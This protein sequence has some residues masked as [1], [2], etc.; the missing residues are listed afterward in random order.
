VSVHLSVCLSVCICLQSIFTLSLWHAPVGTADRTVFIRRSSTPQLHHPHRRRLLY[1][2]LMAD[3][4]FVIS[5][6]SY[7]YD[8][9]SLLHFLF[10]VASPGQPPIS[11]NP[12]SLRSYGSLAGSGRLVLTAGTLEATV[13]PRSIRQHRQLFDIPCT[14]GAALENIRPITAH[15]RS[16][17]L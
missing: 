14:H 2:L 8:Y 16:C 15:P 4:I 17:I 1:T 5:T 13:R 6:G 9:C 3:I 12:S 7:Y 11:P 10:S